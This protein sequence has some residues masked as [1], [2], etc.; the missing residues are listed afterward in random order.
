LDEEEKTLSLKT[1]WI[2]MVIFL[3]IGS[4][5]IYDYLVL[6]NKREDKKEQEQHVVWL[7]GKKLA[8]IKV[9]NGTQVIRFECQSKDGCTFDGTAN[10]LIKEPLQD[11][12][13]S[14]SV[15]SLASSI[16][17]LTFQDKLDFE[18][19]LDEV[20]FGLNDS[21]LLA[22]LQLMGDGAP[23]Q[24]KVGRSAPVGPNV[25]LQ[26][27]GE[28]NRLFTVGTLFSEMLEKDLFH[29]RNKRIFPEVT[30]DAVDAISWKINGR[31]I[32]A[33]KEKG[34]WML[35]SPVAANADY[36]MIESLVST[37]VFASAKA[38]VPQGTTVR[39]KKRALEIM[40]GTN[41]KQESFYLWDGPGALVTT[42]DTKNIFSVDALV[43]DRF[44]KN[45]IDYRDR[46]IF[47]DAPSL[48]AVEEIGFEFPKDRLKL[49]LK[50]VKGEWQA[51]K[52]SDDPISQ[53]RIHKFLR[54][55]LSL[56]AKDI[57]GRADRKSFNGQIADLVVS[58][59]QLPS[60]KFVISNRKLATTEYG[61]QEL[62]LLSEDFTK[63][64]PIREVDL[65]ESGNK[66]VLEELKGKPH[67]DKFPPSGDHSGHHH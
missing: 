5:A 30:V 1:I 56:E 62:G 36:V 19:P 47:K 63:L 33:K 39:E 29:W 60:Q 57:K 21:K 32:E 22:E 7:R 11:L 4:F 52:A 17:N 42:S 66:Q 58:V 12:A 31:K 64:L 34:V 37:V 28:R 67:G 46:K 48:E 27:N 54:A 9:K 24:F 14:S 6:E 53:D 41:S 49:T 10:W 65:R 44:K 26:L 55:Y 25:Y 16:L 23:L 3:S 59:P 15:A 38:E 50:Q 13:D 61:S 35:T 40:F 20:E 8:G 2:L 51:D 43:F 45:L 18:V